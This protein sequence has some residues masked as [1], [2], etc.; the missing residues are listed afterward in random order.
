MAKFDPSKPF[1]EIQ[2]LHAARYVQD[3]KYFDAA[4]N[5]LEEDGSRKKTAGKAPVDPKLVAAATGKKGKAPVDPKLVAAATGKKGK[6]AAAPAAV[7]A[8]VPGDADAQ[9]QAQLGSDGAFQ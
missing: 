5:E 2:G 6:A 7:P 9:L 3:D 1:G 8:A 4:G